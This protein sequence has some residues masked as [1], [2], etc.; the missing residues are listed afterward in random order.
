MGQYKRS[1]LAAA[2]LAAALSAGCAER[3]VAV[4][5]ARLGEA[6]A[7][8]QESS[9]TVW[10]QTVRQQQVKGACMLGIPLL[11]ILICIVLLVLENRGVLLHE[12]YFVVPGIVLF[13][14][15]VVLFG[16]ASTAIGH[17]VNPEYYAMI[18]L[19]ERFALR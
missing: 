3:T 14:A 7:E 16:L 17:I 5:S 11:I 18:D 12:V 2:V 15:V 9:P 10:N 13:W 1:I 6:V 8:L 19:M 4:D